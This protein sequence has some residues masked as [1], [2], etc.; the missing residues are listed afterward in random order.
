MVRT[1]FVYKHTHTHTLELEARSRNTRA[2]FVGVHSF[3]LISNYFLIQHEINGYVNDEWI[4][5]N[6]NGMANIHFIIRYYSFTLIKLLQAN[7]N[8]FSYTLLIRFQFTI[9][10]MFL[11]STYLLNLFTFIQPTNLSIY[12]IHRYWGSHVDV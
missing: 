11:S 5:L 12:R 3:W 4:D 7:L 2:F 6:F 10:F 1:Q 8:L 9:I